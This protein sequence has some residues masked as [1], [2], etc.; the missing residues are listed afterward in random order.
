MTEHLRTDGASMDSQAFAAVLAAVFVCTL[1]W[2][3]AT[4]AGEMPEQAVA[5]AVAPSQL[6]SPSL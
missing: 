2:V 6:R 1:L 4:V 5:I 3:I